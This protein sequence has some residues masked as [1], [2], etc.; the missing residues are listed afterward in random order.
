MIFENSASIYQ[1]EIDEQKEKE[2]KNDGDGLNS[3][4]CEQR[5]TSTIIS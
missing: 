4:M 5:L 3:P 2:E 1:K